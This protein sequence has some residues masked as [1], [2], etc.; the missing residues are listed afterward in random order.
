MAAPLTTRQALQR[1]GSQEHVRLK[2][3]HR[4]NGERFTKQSRSIEEPGKPAG[5]NG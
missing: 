3:H 2:T 4:Y 1:W 5:K